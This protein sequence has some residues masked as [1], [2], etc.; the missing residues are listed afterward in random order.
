MKTLSLKAHCDR[1]HICMGE[2][3]SPHAD[4]LL[5]TIVPGDSLAEERQTWLAVSQAGL[6]QAYGDDE[7]DYSDCF[8]KA[9]SE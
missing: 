3:C 7:P 1:K 2:P 5:G 8:G 6:A 4:E 9:P